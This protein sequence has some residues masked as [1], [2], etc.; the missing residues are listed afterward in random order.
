MSHALEQGGIEHLGWTLDRYALAAIYDAVNLNT[1]ATGN[2]A[3][4]KAP[5][6]EPFYRPKLKKKRRK[7]APATGGPG[8]LKKL[9]A[10]IAG[11]GRG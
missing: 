4:G 1:R 2:W 10:R 11:G 5:K 7:E 3:K 6:F 8:A 9:Y